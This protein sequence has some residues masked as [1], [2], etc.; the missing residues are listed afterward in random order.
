M[1]QDIVN[2][3]TPFDVKMK[4]KRNMI[5]V[6]IFSI[7][8][9][10]AGLTS[11]YIVSMGGSFWVKYPFPTAFFI[12]TAA[13]LISSLTYHLAVKGA[14]KRNKKTVQI[15][16]TLTLILGIAFSFFQFKGYQQLV[17]NGA[18]LVSPII[19][20]DGRYGDY[21]EV[22]QDGHFV[23]VD[24]NNYMLQGELM[25]AEQMSKLQSY[26][27]HFENIK[28]D[29]DPTFSNLPEGFSLYFKNEPLQLVNGRFIKTDGTGLQ[30]VD[31]H[32]LKMLSLHVRDGRGDFF[33]KGEYG[34]DFKIYFK[35]NELEYSER[36][37]Y[38]QGKKLS[39]PLQNKLSQAR[40]TATSYLYI[41][42][43]LHLLHILVT[44][45]YQIRM[46]YISFSG[47]LNDDKYL[48]LK[49]GGVFWHFL[50]ILWIYLLLFLI[51]I[52]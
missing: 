3:T 50:D 35:G 43:A 20:S 47:E 44:L 5:Y 4:M 13:I 11:A 17:N 9:V 52:H 39:V 36:T 10:F 27:K 2:E 30:T 21:Y 8:M 29:G 45:I 46:V 42:T 19:V 22:K 51:F 15:Y 6:S 14:E 1:R 24:G 7:V 34:K 12:S 38:Y 37:L 18:F 48:K 33:H 40:D 31:L 28:V 49:F 41:I 23:E 16:I 26:F 32:R 25:T